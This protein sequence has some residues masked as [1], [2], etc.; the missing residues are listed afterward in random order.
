MS[1]LSFSICYINY[2][3]P[4]NNFLSCVSYQMND[5]IFFYIDSKVDYF[6]QEVNEIEE[7]QYQTI[8]ANNYIN[9]FLPILSIFLLNS[10]L[11]LFLL[12]SL[13]ASC[14]LGFLYYY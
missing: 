8:E 9:V 1:D 14:N 12:K 10:F 13:F 6:M 3:I 4:F 2:L 7:H 11:S 5:I